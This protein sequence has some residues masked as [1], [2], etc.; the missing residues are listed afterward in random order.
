MSQFITLIIPFIGTSAGATAVFFLKNKT[1]DKA[2]KAML[3]FASGVMVAAAVWSLI[4]PS[5]EMTAEKGETPWL[6]AVSGFMAGVVFLLLS[7]IA[8][9][10]LRPQ[11]KTEFS[12]TLMLIF[13]VT[14]HNI[15][16]GM[17]VGVA[18]AGSLA[19][20]SGITPAAVTALSLGIALQ[21]LPE[22][23]IISMPLIGKTSKPKA[24]ACGV[25]S[26]SVEPVFGFIT[27]IFVSKLSVLLPYLLSFAAGAMFYVVYEEL[28]P[29]SKSGNCGCTGI[30]SSSLGFC[31]MMLL[32]VALG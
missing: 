21:N 25:L 27:V 32:D 2:E 26:G 31:L 20:N 12:K 23:A 6:P 3:G 5:I 17:A 30:I 18:I 14:L 10:N 24:F 19:E 9:A 28:I 15:P 16:E 1:T 11:G 4:I 22:G 8:V 29:E 7:D 13:A